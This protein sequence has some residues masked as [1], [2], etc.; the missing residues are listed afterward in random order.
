MVATIPPG[1]DYTGG[2]ILNLC[3]S[4]VTGCGGAPTPWPV[5]DLLK[6]DDLGRRQNL[7]LFVVDGLGYEFLR[8]YPDSFLHSRLRGRL[9]SVFPTTTA[10]AI[11]AFVSGLSPACH[12]ITGW[13]TWL[14]EAG[15]VWTMLPFVPRDPALNRHD[16]AFSADQILS[17]PSLFQ[18]IP[19]V[20]HIVT[21]QKLMDSEYSLATGVGA[22]RHG[23]S[24]LGEM[25]TLTDA[26][27]Q[28]AEE[29]QYIYTYWP[30][31][32]ALCHT[33]GT[34]A[35]EVTAHF[36]QLDQ[37]F[38]EFDRAL[39]GSD[40]VVL[41]TADHGLIDTSPER[42]I[43]LED[44]PPL[45]AMLSRPLCGEPRAVF[46]YVQEDRH[47]AFV[48]YVAQ[49]L[50][51]ACDCFASADLITAGW[52]GPQPGHPALASRVGDFTLVMKANYILKDRLVGERAFSQIGVHGGLSDEERY[53]PLV[54]FEG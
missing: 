53:V 47:A 28:G 1:P 6:D 31:L 23:Y 22:A 42:S 20:S 9:G 50:G 10:T 54:V 37:A 29:K 30:H 5:A 35:P 39:Q 21:P 3:S 48:D 7:V 14:E 4:I 38:A 12:G 33:H 40:T 19:R 25:F 52:F 15:T 49:Y 46:C 24:D 8:R 27:I 17:G 45:A 2:G 18:Q 16:F 11:T 41:V 44:H 32:D 51:H 34:S 43:L 26:L 13:F 36:K